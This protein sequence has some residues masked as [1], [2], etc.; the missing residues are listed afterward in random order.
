MA[1]T[2]ATTQTPQTPAA[3]GPV[4]TRRRPVLIIA[5]V[6]ALLLSALGGVW[7][8]TAA[9]SSVEVV[10]ARAAI[11]RGA[12]IAAGDLVV[13]RVSLDPAIASIPARAR[14]AGVVPRSKPT[15][16]ARA[17]GSQCG[18]PSP[19]TAGTSVTP[20]SSGTARAASARY[21]W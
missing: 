16:T 11:P 18:A 5:S 2:T 6:A 10:V 17:C 13:A 1:P 20:W 9:T 3:L 8:W 15:S 4:K 21:S 12:I 7:L 19:A 14:M